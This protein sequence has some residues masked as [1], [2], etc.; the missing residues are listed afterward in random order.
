M[1]DSGKVD[2]Y[3]SLIPSEMKKYRPQKDIKEI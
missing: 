1:I 3:G 2:D